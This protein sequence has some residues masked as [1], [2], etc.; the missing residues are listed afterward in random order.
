MLFRAVQCVLAWKANIMSQI[1]ELKK[2][3]VRLFQNMVLSKLVDFSYSI[4]LFFYEYDMR[5]YIYLNKILNHPV[6]KIRKIQGQYCSSCLTTVT[7]FKCKNC[8]LL[9]SP[10]PNHKN[11][12]YELT[13]MKKMIKN[14]FDKPLF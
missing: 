7:L 11:I 14:G 2:C 8:R 12:S 13:V 6:S 3:S 10:H 1:K 9:M 4:L 5:Y